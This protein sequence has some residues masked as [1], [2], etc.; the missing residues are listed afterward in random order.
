MKRRS[1]KVIAVLLVLS[2]TA[3]TAFAQGICPPAKITG[4]I[5]VDVVPGL[6]SVHC[7]QI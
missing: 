2:L 6:L 1:V 3:V 7:Q 5:E 4:D